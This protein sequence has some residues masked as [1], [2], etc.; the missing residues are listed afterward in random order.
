MRIWHKLFLIKDSKINI[1]LKKDQSYF[2]HERS[3]G[4]YNENEYYK[5]QEIFL[6]KYSNSRYQ[7]YT[8][9]IKEHLPK[10]DKILSIGSGRCVPE[11]LLL[12]DGYNIV[13]S[14][15]EIPNC[16]E[17]SK[18]IYSNFE[19]K[20]LD[21]LSE[22][23]DQKFNS[24]LCFSMIYLFEKKELEIFFKK[25][26]NSL[27][28]NGFLILDPGGGEDIMFSYFYD[29]I[30]LTIE[31]WLILLIS[32][33]FRRKYF[34]FKKHQGYRFSNRELIKF[35]KENGFEFI[36]IKEGEYNIEFTRSKIFSFLMK[37]FPITKTI[38]NVCGKFFP[39]VRI[40]KFRKI[41]EKISAI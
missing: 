1:N 23:L 30:Y 13:C 40:F 37:K 24:M 32:K 25:I 17:A 22:S 20:K 39:Y 4:D 29:N 2:D 16:Y 21:I 27:E 5:S 7:L 19:Y 28:S 15:I 12:N 18:K 35:A 8:T 10:T 6:K 26:H 38:F 36:E 3:M 31:S 14:D 11:L 34:L 33:L 9:F 41:N